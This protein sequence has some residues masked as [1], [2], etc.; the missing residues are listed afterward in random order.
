MINSFINEITY[1]FIEISPYLILGFLVSGFLF[2]F[3]SKE[4]VANN[5]GKPGFVS[6][7]KASLFGVPMPLCSC[8]VIPVATSMH[9]RGASK[10]ATLS[11]LIS[12][13]Q[14]GIDSIL[15]TLNQMGLQF[16]IIRPI[17]ALLTG[18]IGGLLGEK[19]TQNEA[20]EVIKQNQTDT[21]KT[22]VDGIKYAF[23]TVPADIIKPLL[24]GIIISGL[25][26]ILI[27]NDFFASYN[28]TGLSAMVLVA[29]AS[30]P[31]YVCATAS[32]PVAMSLMAKGLEPGAA[33][34]FLMAGPATNAAT[35][36]VIL[37]SLGKKIVISYVSVIFVSSIL[38]G[39]L[40]NIFLDPN[41]IPMNMDHHHHN[42]NSLWNIFSD[43]SVYTMLIIIFYYLFSKIKR[44]SNAMDNLNN[45][46][47]YLITGMTCNHCKQTATEAIENCTGVEKVEIDLDSGK[48][49]I[50]GSDIN[51]DEIITSIKSVGF[52]IK[53]HA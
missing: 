12:T 23:I 7:S 13:P 20:N 38:F 43:L 8:G 41:T 32:V 47:A 49:Y 51:D 25:I 3:T 14:T 22:Y 24:K 36:S 11:F 48:A 30:V 10:G 18:I 29:V 9:K 1:L 40:I 33:F 45:D 5:L 17:V 34:V 27:P 16:A 15:L 52:S 35:I 44:R 50:Q 46:N 28:F 42:H 4:M 2:I 31:I 26:A 21:K 39:S 53:K 19:L 37:N 6:V